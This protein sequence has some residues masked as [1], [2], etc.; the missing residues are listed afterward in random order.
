[1][2]KDT[3]LYMLTETSPFMMSF[4]IITKNGNAVIVDGGRAEDMP[5]LK[6]YVDGRH[7]SAWIFTHPHVDHISGFISEWKKNRC[8]DFDIERLVYHFPDKAWRETENVPD[9]EYFLKDFDET[10]PEFLDIEPEFAHLAVVPKQGDSLT[11]DEIK[12]DFIFTW[13]RELCSNPMNDASLV[14]KVTTPNKSVL[15]LGDLGPEGGDVLLNESKG[16]LK[17]DI[18]QMAHHGHM[19]CGMDVYAEIMPEV[20]LWCAPDWLYA[21]GDYPTYLADRE[22]L[23]K[24]RRHRMFG[25]A[26]TRKRMELLRV[27]K[28]LITKDG[29]H[30][31]L[32]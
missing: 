16:L 23:F 11:V 27:K 15:F 10:L 6:K 20:C 12:I 18:V 14:F 25:T 2:N 17:S 21:E 9:N 1:M 28:H 31:I 13:H 8:S 4:V 30:K 32:L 7:I 24:M 19:D 26:V 5:L 22:R 29:T 3:A